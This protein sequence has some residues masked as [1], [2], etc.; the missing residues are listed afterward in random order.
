[1]EGQF[2]WPSGIAVDA[3]RGV[4]AVT[5]KNNHRVCVFEPQGGFLFSFGR[6]GDGPGEF[7]FP[8]DVAMDLE[9]NMVVVDEEGRVQAFEPDGA[10]IGNVGVRG[11]DEPKVLWGV[12]VGRDGRVIVSDRTSNTVEAF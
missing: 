7:Q 1:M 11:S 9:G 2:E 6:Q 5:D 3:A 8:W 4:L 12:A 10:F